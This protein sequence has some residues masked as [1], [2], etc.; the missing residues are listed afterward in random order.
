MIRLLARGARLAT[1]LIVFLMALAVLRWSPVEASPPWDVRALPLFGPLVV[2]AA[3]AAACGGPRRAGPWRPLALVLAGALA[4]LASVVALRPSGGLAV[5]VSGPAGALGTLAAGTIEVDGPRLRGL[6]PVRKW[7]FDWSGPLDVPQTGTYR[8]WAAGRGRVTVVL[9][10]APILDADGEDLRAGADVPLGRGAHDL[11]VTL[12]RTGPGPRLRLG[13]TRPDG[14]DET[15]PVR[16][17]GAPTAR[18][19]WLATDALALVVAALVG[20]LVLAVPWDARRAVPSP[21]PFTAGE[22]AVSLAGHAALFVLMSWPLATDP[23]RLGVMDRPDGRLNAWILAWDAHA[24]AHAPGRLFD[25]PAFHPLPD[26]L[27]FSENLLL[28]AV[29]VSPALAAGEPVLAYNLV[30]ALS[31]VASGL[32]TQLVVRRVSGARLAA[33]VGGAVFAVGAH[34]FIRLAHPHAQVTMFLPLALLAFDRFW[35]KPTLGRALLVGL[36]LGLQALSSIYLAAITATALAVAAGLALAAGMDR[37]A[38]VR[39]AAGGALAAA[40]A[41]PVAL[42]YLRM[43]AFQG[44]EWTLDDIAT[45]ATTLTSY[46]AS[47]SRLYGGV[48]QRHLDPTA[49]QDTLFPGVLVLALGLAG[50]ASAPRRYRAVALAASA[51]AIVISLGPETAFYR[52]LHE[53]VVF[54]RGVRALSRFSLLPVLALSVLTGLALAGRRRLVLPALALILVEST[55][56][57]LRYHW[58]PGTSEAARS[59]RGG[60]GAVVHLPLGAGDTQAMLDA[61]AHWRPLVNGDSGFVPVPYTRAMELLDGPPSADALRFL[62]AIG[63]T[64]VVSADALGLPETASYGAEHVYALPAGDAAAVPAPGTP[65]AT[66]WGPD[67]AF[68]DLGAPTVVGRVAFVIGPGAW[69]D[70]PNVRVSRDGREWNAVPAVASLADATLA[71]YRDPRNGRGALVFPPVTARYLRID[72]RLPARRGVLE[73]AP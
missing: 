6:T 25:A 52:F 68:L 44:V 71:L 27:A 3:F 24:L 56:A 48:T 19:W 38:L 33:F 62:H 67:G 63:V 41:A 14:R 54:V 1:G 46:A 29:L 72:P 16:A 34:R 57:P 4:L 55:N 37:R 60:R 47:G 20:A 5:S 66:A 11:G 64:Q 39:L 22:C 23:A 32:G 9:D 45:Y 7:T 61:T 65:R 50:L 43:R 59:L 40:L 28:P 17:L 49:V 30:L 69:L 18:G 12:T 26:A 8:L 53:H 35:R 2:L 70:A 21:G 42:P 51:L 13:W 36:M 15:I 58:W 73:T 10:G 31:M